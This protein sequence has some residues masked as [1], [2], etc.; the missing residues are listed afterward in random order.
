MD[1]TGFG[2]G[3][4]SNVCTG[5]KNTYTRQVV[6][7]QHTT[8]TM[9]VSASGQVL[10]TFVIFEKSFPSG[11]Y[12]DGRFFWCHQHRPGSDMPSMHGPGKDH[13]GYT[14]IILGKV[15]C[16]RAYHQTYLPSSIFREI[17]LSEM[18]NTHWKCGDC[19]YMYQ[20]LETGQAW[21]WGVPE[22][23]LPSFVFNRWQFIRTELRVRDGMV[24]CLEWKVRN[25]I[26]TD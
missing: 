21:S 18:R 9:C 15:D 10:P 7:T 6:T 13:L 2:K 25:S 3:V 24:T 5:N 4:A 12:R 14:N 26:I 8:A 23:Y 11:A 1:E 22:T 17:R 19:A 20:L 16:D